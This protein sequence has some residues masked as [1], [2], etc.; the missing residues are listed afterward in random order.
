MRYWAKY[1]GRAWQQFKNRYFTLLS[2]EE[3]TTR[4]S[5]ATWIRYE[6]QKKRLFLKGVTFDRN[7]FADTGGIRALTHTMG[8]AGAKARAVSRYPRRSDTLLTRP[9]VHNIHRRQTRIPAQCASTAERSRWLQAYKIIAA[10]ISTRP[11]F[12]LRPAR[13]HWA[14]CSTT[15]HG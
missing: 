13:G 4:K 10:E 12:T 6:R 9:R 2:I 15:N 8:Y 3:T 1:S 14:A 7:N 11:E 5:R